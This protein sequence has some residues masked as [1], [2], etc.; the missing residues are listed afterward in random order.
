MHQLS[1]RRW[2]PVLV[3]ALLALP[4]AAA[5][6]GSA[7]VR[8][9]PTVLTLRPGEEGTVRIRIE[10]VEDLAGAEIHLT[11]DA[12]VLEVVDADAQMEGLQIA[13]GDLLAADFIA[14]NAADP[15]T[16]RIDYA[17]ARMPP[18]TPATGDGVLAVI[19]VRAK[20]EGEGT[21]VLRDVLL[22][23]SEGYPIPA[24]VASDVVAVTVRT[25]PSLPCWPGGAVLLGTLGLYLHA[26]RRTRS[27][28]G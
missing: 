8:V 13:H 4:M 10:G 11:Y 16:G 26:R 27:L 3:I 23:N 19:T 22:A 1:V 21:L 15:Q 18:H 28:P 14:Q 17:V 12:D 5:A 24:E 7:T 20:G 6:Q 25:A 9:E 2:I